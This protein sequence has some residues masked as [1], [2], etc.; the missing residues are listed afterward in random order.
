MGWHITRL[1]AL[2]VAN[3]KSAGLHADGGGLHLKVTTG[4]KSWIFRFKHKGRTHD[5][6][7]GPLTV[8]SLAKARAMAACR[9]AT[10]VARIHHLLCTGPKGRAAR[11]G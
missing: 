4:T 5:M 9:C 6:D 3:T 10:G 7:L 1:N 2:E 11:R 8:I